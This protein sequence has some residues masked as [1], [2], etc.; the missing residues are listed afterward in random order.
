MIAPGLQR[1]GGQ[2]AIDQLMQPYD[3]DVPGASLLVLK[4]GKALVR[5]GYGR[6]DLERG[7]AAGTD[8]NYRLASVSKQ[9]TA[10]AILLLLA[11]VTLSYVQIGK[12]NPGGGGA[13]AVAKK[14]LGEMPA[15][16]AA[17]SVFADYVLTAAVSVSAGTAAS[18]AAVVPVAAVDS[19]GALPGVF[20]APCFGSGACSRMKSRNCG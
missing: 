6:A 13:Y 3:G 14:N 8:T 19:T 9:F 12:A 4:D 15:L 5:R 10:A 11:L 7:I 20:V 16:V 18:G 2:A 1:H 17:G